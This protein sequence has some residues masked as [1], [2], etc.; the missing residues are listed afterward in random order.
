MRLRVR[1]RTRYRFDQPQ[2]RLVQLLR[3]TP[4]NGPGQSVVAWDIEVDRDARLRRARD[5]YNNRVTM[6]YVDGPLDE[7]T[8][9][10]R[11]EV[12]TEDRAGVLGMSGETLPPLAFLQPTDLTRPDR[13]LAAF[14]ETLALPEEPL[15]RAH[16]LNAGVHA[17][18]DPAPPT[19]GTDQRASVRLAERRA[20]PQGATHVL[21]AAARIAGIPARYAAGHLFRPESGEGHAAHGWAELHVDGHGWIGFDPTLGTCPGERHVRVAIGL[22]HA[23]AA[24]I[25]GARIGG[26][27][28]TLAVDVRVA[29]AAA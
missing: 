13:A 29:V 27:R 28:E 18:L 10:V 20:D 7:I 6:L 2:A 23:Q 24:P 4:R 21:L 15:A 17:R 3:V 25:S 9:A 26:G 19:L 16:A 22:D 1:H 11:G 14:V 12:L 8:V 5:G